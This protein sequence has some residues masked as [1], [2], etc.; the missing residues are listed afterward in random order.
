MFQDRFERHAR[1][2]NL[3]PP[4]NLGQPVPQGVTGISQDCSRGPARV[5]TGAAKRFVKSN[6][7]NIRHMAFKRPGV[8][9][10]SASPKIFLLLGCGTQFFLEIRNAQAR[11]RDCFPHLA[12]FG[13]NDPTKSLVLSAGSNEDTCTKVISLSYSVNF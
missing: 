1:S 10:S 3:G 11:L 13:S 7:L 6:R 9:F 5:F 4:V 2:V 8:Q 12:S